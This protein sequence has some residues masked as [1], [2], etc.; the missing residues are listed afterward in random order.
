MVI[1]FVLLTTN[2]HLQQ[3]FCNDVWIKT[4]AKITFASAACNTTRVTQEKVMSSPWLSIIIPTYN[5]EKTIVSALKSILFQNFPAWEVLVMDGDSIDSTVN[6]VREFQTKDK[7]IL[8]AS[9]K[10]DGIYDAMNKGIKK[11][12]GEWIYFLGADDSLYNRQVLQEVATVAASESQAELIYGNVQLNKELGYHHKELIYA[13]K[14][15]SGKL[16]IK[17]ICHQSAFYHCSLF[18]KFGLFRT[19]YKIFADYDFNLRCF[20]KV[21]SVYLDSIIANFN[22]GGQSKEKQESDKAFENDFLEN[23]AVNYSYGYKDV[24]FNGKKRQLL[25]LLGR[26]LTT[27]NVTA[28]FKIFQILTYQ[29]FK[30]IFNK[31]KVQDQL[32]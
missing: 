32:T 20:N 29:A 27:L 22:V 16:L 31:N 21:R 26:Q 13:G 8:L 14:F 2:L 12:R 7:R 5:S 11:A 25:N 10:D 19:E 30:G 24:Y 18:H 6:L 17:N 23:I 28:L 3:K 9:E 4:L 1:L 15:D